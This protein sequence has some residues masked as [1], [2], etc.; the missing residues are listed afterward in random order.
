AIPCSFV[1]TEFLIRSPPQPSSDMNP[2]TPSNFLSLP[3]LRKTT[4]CLALW[5]VV[6]FSNSVFAATNRRIGGHCQVPDAVD[7]NCDWGDDFNWAVPVPPAFDPTTVPQN[8]GTA[9][10][11][12]AGA[13]GLTPNM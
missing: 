7:Q 12:F 4:G 13:V 1:S 9:D 3:S 2:F 8:D 6:Y 11:V 5:L 10:I